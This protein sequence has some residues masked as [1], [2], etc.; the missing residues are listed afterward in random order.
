MW[1]LAVVSDDEIR[2]DTE[3]GPNNFRNFRNRKLTKTL[4]SRCTFIMHG[5][6]EDNIN[7]WLL[8]SA[9]RFTDCERI[10]LQ[11]LYV[12]RKVQLGPAVSVLFNYTGTAAGW[13]GGLA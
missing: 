7:I 4:E 12:E 9:R 8:G 2:R 1:N 11:L 3:N 10:N 5:E 6:V 13:T